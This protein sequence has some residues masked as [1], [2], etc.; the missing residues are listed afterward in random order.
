MLGVAK[1]VK[2]VKDFNGTRRM[3][4]MAKILRYR[5]V[6][7]GLARLIILYTPSDFYG[8]FRPY[9]LLPYSFS[10]LIRSK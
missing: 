6:M 5:V 2:D 10:R 1:I 9:T 7:G 4:G 3:L 8:Y